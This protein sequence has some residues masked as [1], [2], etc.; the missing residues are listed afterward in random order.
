MKIKVIVENVPNHRLSGNTFSWF[1]NYQPGEQV[2]IGTTKV[3]EL[4]EIVSDVRA[5]EERLIRLRLL[6][7]A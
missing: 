6:P 1:P 4:F 2:K 7:N 3:H 5:G